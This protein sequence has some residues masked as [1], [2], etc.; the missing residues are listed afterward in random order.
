[1]GINSHWEHNKFLS[2]KFRYLANLLWDKLN[3]GHFRL[4]GG[5]FQF[6]FIWGEFPLPVVTNPDVISSTHLL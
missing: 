3:H 2:T 4:G 1:M 6:F 5:G